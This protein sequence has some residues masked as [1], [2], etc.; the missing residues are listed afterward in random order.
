MKTEQ[1]SHPFE[2]T[3]NFLEAQLKFFKNYLG[4]LEDM[5]KVTVSYTMNDNGDI[6]IRMK[7]DIN[8]GTETEL[9]EFKD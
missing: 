2:R 3:E 5:K 4:S 8:K 7:P 1:V 6:L 9:D